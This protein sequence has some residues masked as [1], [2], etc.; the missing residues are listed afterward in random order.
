MARLAS[1]AKGGFFATPVDEMELVLRGLHVD[2][3]KED[4]PYF[5]YDPCCG[6][7]VAL[8]MLSEE[9]K[10][11]GAKQ[12]RAYGAEL[13]AG[14]AEFAQDIL[15]VVIADGY[16]N[17][18]TE[19][20]FSLLWLNPPYQDGFSERTELTFL[21]ALTGAKQGVLIKGGWLLFCIPQYVLKDT[22]G[23]L[24]ARFQDIAVYRFT[25]ANYET[26]KQV[27]V[28]AR[29]GKAP[30]SEQK[31]TYKALITIGEGEKDLLPTLE[32]MM[33]IIVPPCDQPTAPMFRAGPM[34]LLELAKDIQDSPLFEEI[35]KRL[36][37]VGSAVA[38]KRPL[39]PLK[40]AHM[41]VAIA[42]GAVG[43]NMGTHF[44]SGV[45]KQRTD[46]EPI[47]DEETGK[48][49]GERTTLHFTSIVRAFTPAGIFDL[50]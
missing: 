11:I 38:M 13:E 10:R 50:K 15:D 20:K 41:G 44:I 47:I 34:D 21:R 9:M 48:R 43:G 23:V 1:E 28:L 46:V 49:K 25:D 16:Q 6:E 36:V 4:D 37:P 18:R 17:V 42:S 12:C 19:P 7:G 45:T 24:S 33:P 22:A 29:F 39:L 35:T 3:G 40:A 30:A 14:R 8:S 2:E 27:V 32:E 26:F 31:R 5:I